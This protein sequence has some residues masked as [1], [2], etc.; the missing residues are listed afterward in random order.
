MENNSEMENFNEDYYVMEADGADNHPQLAWGETSSR[1]FISIKEID[2][3][4]LDLPLE[5]EFDTPYP[6]QPEMV[7]ILDLGSTC[8]LSEKIKALFDKLKLPKVQFIPTTIITNKKQ[9]IEKGYYIFN[10][11]NGISGIDKN[12]YIGDPINPRGRILNLKKFSLDADILNKIALDERLLFRLSESPILIIIHKSIKEVLE[13][14]QAT[15]FRFY[16]INKWSPSAI[17]E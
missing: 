8:V 11:W 1:P 7:D 3:D 14:E 17:F 9:R 15:G 5:I 4:D 16:Q 12:S 2:S 6:R 13:N 10:S